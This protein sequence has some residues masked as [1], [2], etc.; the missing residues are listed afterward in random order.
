MGRERRY[1]PSRG[2]HPGGLHTGAKSATYSVTDVC[3]WLDAVSGGWPNP[4]SQESR[5]QPRYRGSCGPGSV[6]T[7]ALAGLGD[8]EFRFEHHCIRGIRKRRRLSNTRQAR[9]TLSRFEPNSEV[10]P[11]LPVVY[12]GIHRRVASSIRPLAFGDFAVERSVYGDPGCSRPVPDTGSER[13]VDPRPSIRGC[14]RPV[15]RYS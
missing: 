1:G 11:P 15:R 7:P 9:V 5:I 3:A 10:Q 6:G 13:R 2:A 8:A 4:A 14:M 12:L